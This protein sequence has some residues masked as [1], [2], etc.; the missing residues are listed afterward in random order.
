MGILLIGPPGSGKGTQAKYIIQKLGIPVI[1]TGSILREVANSNTETANLVSKIVDQGELV[2]DDL[3]TNLVIDRLAQE[4]CKSGYL[5][6]GFPRNL[7]Q[8]E[9]LSAVGIYPNLVLQINVTDEEILRRI[10]GRWIHPG[11]GRIYHETYSPSKVAG[12]DDLTG[13]DLVKRAD[14]SVETVKKRLQIYRKNTYPV[15][16]YYERLSAQKKPIR[17][18]S[19]SGMAPVEQIAEIIQYMILG[20]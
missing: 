17:C 13:E 1:A 12:K 15:Y 7:S 4:D 14:D 2:P 20:S 16:T 3:V 10:T 8:A 18:Q 9:S 19:I 11:S 6:D 5:L